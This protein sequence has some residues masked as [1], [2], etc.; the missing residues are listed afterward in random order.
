M[1]THLFTYGSLMCSDI[2]YHVA[3]CRTNFVPAML[4]N[5]QRSKMRG[6]EYPAIIAAPGEKTEGILYLD[7]PPTA[8]LRLDTFEGEQYIRQEVIVTTEP[9]GPCKAMTYILHPR[10][11]HLFTGETWNYQEFLVVG[12][13]LFL[14]SYLGFRKI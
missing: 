13:P 1:M 14:K 11:H 4:E 2:M 10:Y 7:L 5:F 3:D 9:D 12:K 8:I 6:Q